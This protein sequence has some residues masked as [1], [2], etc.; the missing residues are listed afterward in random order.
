MFLS[1]SEYQTWISE[2]KENKNEGHEF[3]EANGGIL[4]DMN[5]HLSNVIENGHKQWKKFINS[6]KIEY[7]KNGVEMLK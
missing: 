1:D 5:L 2:N 6:V 7:Y 3:V 4:K